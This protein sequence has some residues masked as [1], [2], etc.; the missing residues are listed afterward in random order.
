M[1]EGKCPTG[2]HSASNEL[3]QKRG[4]EGL[5]EPGKIQ[6]E[7]TK[8]LKQHSSGELAVLFWF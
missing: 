1:L 8:K 5:E 6:E 7:S 4:D 2:H 3:A